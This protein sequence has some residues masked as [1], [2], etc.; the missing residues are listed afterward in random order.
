MSDSE[1]PAETS[2]ASTVKRILHLQDSVSYLLR[3]SSEA[4][5]V[6][7]PIELVEQV[8]TL[9]QK[10]PDDF[11]DKSE[12]QLWNGCDRLTQLIRPTSLESAKLAVELADWSQADKETRSRLTCAYRVKRRNLLWIAGTSILLV[13][14]IVVQGYAVGLNTVFDEAKLHQSRHETIDQQIVALGPNPNP[15]ALLNLDTQKMNEQIR[16]DAVET[17]MERL[18]RWSPIAPSRDS[19]SPQQGQA[20]NAEQEGMQSTPNLTSQAKGAFTIE[21]YARIWRE[22]VLGYIIPA[23]LGL[24]GAGAYVVR[25]TSQAIQ[26]NKYIASVAIRDRVR[27]VQGATFGTLAGII[28][29]AVDSIGPAFEISLPF[30]ALILGYNSEMVFRAMDAAGLRFKKYLSPDSAPPPSHGEN[31]K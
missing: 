11:D 20:Q 12:S 26:N 17:A 23:L 1:N 28:A 13:I 21:V 16:L 15:P 18:V 6:A 5:G 29:T 22:I 8:T 24:I 9:L 30:F 19:K 31:S 4:V 7:V 10:S 14:Y 2:R 27:L 3:F 25:Q